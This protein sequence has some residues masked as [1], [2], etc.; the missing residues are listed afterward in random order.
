MI[1]KKFLE[2]KIISS[3]YSIIISQGE[4]ELFTSVS[5]INAFSFSF[6]LKRDGIQLQRTPWSLEKENVFRID[7][8]GCYQLMF[9]VKNKNNKVVYETSDLIWYIPKVCDWDGEG[10]SHAWLLNKQPLDVC[11]G[12]SHQSISDCEPNEDR[13]LVLDFLHEAQH[14]CPSNILALRESDKTNN[15]EDSE[16]ISFRKLVQRKIDKALQRYGIGNVLVLA[17]LYRFDCADTQQKNIN[18]V[19]EEAYDLLQKVEGV[20]IISMPHSSASKDLSLPIISYQDDKSSLS[21]FRLI[22]QKKYAGDLEIPQIK[23]SLKGNNLTAVVEN[24]LP[25]EAY[26]GRLDLML[27]G[28][29]ID[30]YYKFKVKTPFTW[31]L[32]KT[33][34]YVVQA[35]LSFLGQSTYGQSKAL[36]F[37][38]K[39]SKEEYKRFLKQETEDNTLLGHGL[40]F[41]QATHPLCD[42]LVVSG[43]KWNDKLSK[44]EKTICETHTGFHSD[45][46]G[47]Y[48]KWKTSILTDGNIS[49][50]EETSVL[51][52]GCMVINGVLINGSSELPNGISVDQ[53]DGQCGEFSIVYW[54]QNSLRI[55]LDLFKYF[56]IYQYSKNG[57]QLYSNNYILLLKAVRELRLPCNLNIDKACITL[58]TPGFQPLMQNFSHKMDIEPIKKIPFQY[59]PVLTEKGWGV[60]ESEFGT[61]LSSHETFHE[62]KYRRQLRIAIEEMKEV[63]KAYMDHPCYEYFVIPLSG[64][65]DSRLLFSITHLL[66]HPKA[67]YVECWDYNTP[68]AKKDWMIGT[69]ICGLVQYP[70][71]IKDRKLRCLSFKEEDARMRGLNVGVYYSYKYTGMNSINR[72]DNYLIFYGAGGE[73]ATRPY[74]A[75]RYYSAPLSKQNNID[76]L[77]QFIQSRMMQN[78]LVP[79]QNAF[80]N[81]HLYYTNAL[82]ALPDMSPYERLDRHY[83]E[84]RH[85]IHFGRRNNLTQPV[86]LPMQSK[87]LLRLHHITFDRFKNFRLNLDLLYLANPIIAQFPF[88]DPSV[89]K[90]REKLLGDLVIQPN[91]LPSVDLSLG[92]DEK[93]WRDSLILRSN[94]TISTGSHDSISSDQIKGMLFTSCNTILRKLL[95]TYP[96]LETKIGAG[97][98]H[99]LS[100]HK[101]SQYDIQY[102]YNKLVSLYDQT[103]IIQGDRIQILKSEIQ[104]NK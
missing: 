27:D 67:V 15:I 87:T 2:P 80:D 34:I 44:L 14:Y 33:G 46:I 101:L 73:I 22:M 16:I 54:D 43:T 1:D 30:K 39:E 75:P 79:S 21:E 53:F 9:F 36:F 50:R 7:D 61:I 70:Y 55:S 40:Y 91:D 88:E 68:N 18:W 104:T 95:Q 37:S 19:L 20:H 83:M 35:H 25:P 82:N 10:F 81:F 69:S 3:A 92:K 98:Y 84:W 42:F 24:D 58:G 74:I 11:L 6:M 97:L 51:L 76:L 102:L 28:Q 48:G 5:A 62:E 38:T 71:D 32:N 100:H 64:G 12:Q 89:D 4:A 103:K 63:I 65:L 8:Y 90:D 17:P 59:D 86:A 29:V 57:L 56:H 94:N 72:R 96:K 26:W 23:L 77:A 52:A 13:I 60:V 47:K 99:S 45:F 85:S 78:V 66:K 41:T 93:R 49:H 31:K